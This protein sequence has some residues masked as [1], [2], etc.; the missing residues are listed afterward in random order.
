MPTAL[1]RLMS[2]QGSEVQPGRN[3]LFGYNVRQSLFPGEDAYFKA[4]PHVTGMAAETNDIILNPYS[5]EHVNRDAVARNEAFRLYLRNKNITPGFGITDEQRRAFAGTGYASD[6]NALKSTIAARVF[7]G[8]AS[9]HATPQQRQWVEYLMR[10]YRST[11][12]N[13]TLNNLMGGFY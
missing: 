5:D 4:N 7:S 10:E 2:G 12:P 11:A 6:D 1:E 3:D 13:K 8:D 9:A